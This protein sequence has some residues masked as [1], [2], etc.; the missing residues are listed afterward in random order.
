MTWDFT[1]HQP[2]IRHESD[3]VKVALKDKQKSLFILQ[4]DCLYTLVQDQH[5]RLICTY[6]PLADNDTDTLEQAFTFR[7]DI[8]THHGFSRVDNRCLV[9]YRKSGAQ[10]TLAELTAIVRIHVYSMLVRGIRSS[11]LGELSDAVW[12]WAIRLFHR[13]VACW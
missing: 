3:E 12:R 4:L 10:F 8:E 7:S 5:T 2:Q 11:S 1:I 6:P 13:P 9:K